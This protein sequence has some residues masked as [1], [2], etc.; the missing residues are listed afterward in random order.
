[1]WSS[2][3]WE[4]T[5]E[6]WKVG[7]SHRLCSLY[8]PIAL[9][10]TDYYEER[11][12]ILILFIFCAKSIRPRWKVRS[13]GW[14][15]GRSSMQREK[16]CVLEGRKLSSNVYIICPDCSVS[17]ELLWR[18]DGYINSFF[19]FFDLSRP[20]VTVRCDRLYDRLCNGRGWLSVGRS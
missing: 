11:T 18:M 7:N 5:I 17:Y 10:H 1:M 16:G 4:R 13:S 3:Q 12:V 15:S 6:C 9:F 8:V 14:S 19:Y 2:M 20:V